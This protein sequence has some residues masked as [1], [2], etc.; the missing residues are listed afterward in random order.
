[1]AVDKYND[2]E[3]ETAEILRTGSTVAGACPGG[4]ILSD[5]RLFKNYQGYFVIR[6]V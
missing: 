6:R 3:E 2:F 1:M 4:T 5:R